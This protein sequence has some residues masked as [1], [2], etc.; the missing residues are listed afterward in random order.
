MRLLE[1][2]QEIARQDPTVWVQTPSVDGQTILNGIDELHL[3]SICRRI[4]HQYKMEVD[5]GEAEVIYLETI[6][7]QAEG[8]V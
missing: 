8:E 2:L 1:A 5:V 6:C 4:L 7:K 3:E